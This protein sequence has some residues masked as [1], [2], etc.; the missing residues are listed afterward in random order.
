MIYIKNE[1]E[2]RAIVLG[3]K[4]LAEIRDEILSMVKPG[5]NTADIEEV[6]EKRIIEV[7]GR[8]AF[9][10][11]PLPG[12]IFFP[13][14]VCA[15]LNDEVVHG[16]SLPN[17][18]IK[19]G[20]IVDLDIGMEWPVREDLRKKHNLPFNKHSEFG[21]FFTDTCKTVAAGKITKEA[22]VL[23]KA[24]NSALEEGIKEIKAGMYLSQLGEIIEK[25]AIK[26]NL[27]V[28]KDYVGHGVGYYAH[29]APDIFN[30]KIKFN[31]NDN[32]CLKEGMVIAIEP[33]FNLGSEDISFSD[34]GYTVTTYDG[35]LSAHFEHTVIVTKNS[36]IIA[37]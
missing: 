6:A 27:G 14:V 25:V 36:H 19:S 37:T 26:H 21:G 8:S 7:G 32:I 31:R 17:R 4:L 1:E 33:M 18:V 15:S 11:Y 13:S 12:G 3:G 16:S 5:V 30:Y 35:S 23:L 20:D 29:E 22:R 9:K 28:V 24:T 34:N 2:I 10:N